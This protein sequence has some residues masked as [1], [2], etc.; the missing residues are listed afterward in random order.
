[1]TGEENK[2]R[3]VGEESPAGKG[4]CDQMPK[5]D[6]QSRPPGEASPAG[7]GFCDQMT[8]EDYKSR[9]P[10]EASPVGKG[11]CDQMTKEDYEFWLCGIPG[12]GAK[13][14]LRLRREFPAAEEIFTASADILKKVSGITERDVHNIVESRK[15]YNA[16]YWKKKLGGYGMKCAGIF[17]PVYPEGCRHLYQ[18]PKRLFYIG[19]LPEER[20]RVAVVGARDCSLY[21]RETARAFS[22]RLASCGVAVISGMARGIDGWAHQGALEGGGTTYAV[23]GNGAEI[24]YPKEH[25]RLYRSIVRRGGIIS[26]YPPGTEARPS[27]FPMRNRIISAL[28]DGVLVVEAR[29]KSGSLITADL[30][31]EQGKEVFV[32]PGRAGDA[33]SEGCNNLIKQG[34]CLVTEPEEIM[35]CLGILIPK[36]MKNFRNLNI[37]LETKEKMVYESL[38][39]EPKHISVLAEEQ[40]MEQAEIMRCLLLLLKYGMIL[41]IGNHYYVKRK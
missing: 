3:T 24:C 26:E 31:L 11:F 20:Y 22:A 32:I 14:L 19:K 9:P 33:L 41:E 10:G 35:D 39:F 5:E 27:F 37:R 30:A 12:I 36:E 29:A 38:G 23:L 4:F 21:G 17:S 15:K 28:S 2:C 16:G 1:M 18:P 7:K 13:K 8:K 25:E 40:K 6:N 34:A